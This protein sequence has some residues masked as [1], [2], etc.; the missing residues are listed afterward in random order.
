MAP[1]WCVRVSRSSSTPR[2]S[3]AFGLHIRSTEERPTARQWVGM[4]IALFGF[5]V[6][7][8]G[9]DGE[10]IDVGKLGRRSA[11]P[12]RRRV[13][14][15]TTLTIRF[16]HLAE[17]LAP[18]T[19]LYQL[20]GVFRAVSGC[21]RPHR[22]DRSGPERAAGGEPLDLYP[23]KAAVKSERTGANPKRGFNINILR[24]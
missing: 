12:R 24:R 16:L 9:R 13:M 19:L 5:A 18:A 2:I 22:T 23:P 4:A 3:A 1:L 14:G 7:F 10:S 11:G 8:A 15:A 20:V 6:S 17:T 21:G